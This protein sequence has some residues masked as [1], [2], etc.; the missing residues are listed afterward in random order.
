MSSRTFGG[1]SFPDRRFREGGEPIAG[2]QPPPVSTGEVDQPLQQLQVGP[3][4][5]LPENAGN[6]GGI[7]APS[8]LPGPA[9]QW[10]DRILE[11][12]GGLDSQGAGNAGDVVRLEVGYAAE[13]VVDPGNVLSHP[14]GQLCLRHA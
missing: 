7:G 13:T 2:R 1:V 5:I 14:A 12:V 11:E 8:G 6:L 3:G 10:G 9:P 4:Q